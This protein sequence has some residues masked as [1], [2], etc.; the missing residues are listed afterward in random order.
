[1]RKET[2]HEGR[3]MYAYPVIRY[4]SVLLNK[5]PGLDLEIFD[6]DKFKWSKINISIIEV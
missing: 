3:G 6:D 1:M 4:L 5:N 2:G